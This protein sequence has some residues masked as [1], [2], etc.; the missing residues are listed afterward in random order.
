MPKILD[1]CV[2][3]VKA[4]NKKLPKKKRVNPYAVCVKSTGCRR[5]KGGK[6]KCRKKTKRK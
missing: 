6:W 5:V 3:K 4:K 2:K 1:R